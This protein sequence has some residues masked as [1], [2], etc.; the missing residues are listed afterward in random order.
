V[1]CLLQWD[2][3]SSV[4]VRTVESAHSLNISAIDTGQDSLSVFSG[5]R[6]YTVKEWDA[7]TGTCKSNFS[8]PRNIVTSLKFDQHS[9]SVLFQGSEDLCVRVWDTRNSSKQP[10]VHITAFVYFPVSLSLH[11]KG[12]FLA[13]GECVA[14]IRIIMWISVILRCTCRL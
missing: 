2:V 11:P 6:D 13:T 4:C 14:F 9:R 1:C 12:G 7:E 3:N 10:S 8:A 5:S